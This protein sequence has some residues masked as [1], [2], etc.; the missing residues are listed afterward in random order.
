[1]RKIL[2][3]VLSVLVMFS[4][5]GC[6]GKKQDDRL[7][8]VCTVFL[9]YDF[10]R[11]IAGDLVDLEMLLPFSVESHDFSFDSLSVVELK[12]IASAD[13]FI[14]IG[15][16]SDKGWVEELETT[17]KN[18]SL[19]Y[20]PII[21]AT[22]ILNESLSDSMEHNDAH[23]DHHH[24][25]SENIDEHIWTSPKRAI[26]IVEFLENKLCEADAKNSEIYKSNAKAYKE[27]LLNADKALLKI[28]KSG[29]KLIFADRFAFRYLC[30]DYGFSYDAAF[31]GCSAAT[32]PSVSQ[33]AS[34][35]KSA[36]DSKATSIFY[37]ENS[38]MQRRLCFIRHI[39]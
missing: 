18:N 27:K 6:K 25:D 33:I 16:P 5:C 12:K 3:L 26:E 9:Q 28:E 13:L 22:E 19:E 39:L 2:S 11:E 36:R 38:V 37:L 14:Y 31:P 17:V 7:K 20:L 8:V 10:V 21:E 24:S 15:G 35:T 30:Y 1:M 4:L 29:K 34:L 32:D 23:S